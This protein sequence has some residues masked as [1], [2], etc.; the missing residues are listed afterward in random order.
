MAKKDRESSR[1][2]RREAKRV[3][4]DARQK[5]RA[6]RQKR[7]R[8]ATSVLKDAV[9]LVKH[10]NEVLAEAE[11]LRASLDVVLEEKRIAEEEK[12]ALRQSRD[13]AESKLETAK[14][15]LAQYRSRNAPAFQWKRLAYLEVEESKRFLAAR[16]KE[17]RQKVQQRSYARRCA[18]TVL[19]RERVFE[20][21]E[22]AQS[23][24]DPFL[25][26]AAKRGWCVVTRA[27]PT[28]VN[29]YPEVMLDGSY[30]M[31][32][33]NLLLALKGHKELVHVSSRVVHASHLCGNPQCVV[34]EHVVPETPQKN[35]RRKGCSVWE[36]CFHCNVPIFTCPHEPPCIKYHPDYVD[37]DALIAVAHREGQDPASHCVEGAPLSHA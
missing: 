26:I 5:K 19:N 35:N 33:P 28:K 3:R 12:A 37:M 22:L 30:C 25:A 1:E 18:L 34:K 6:R 21:A 14:N 13:D 11:G 9:V 32:L 10:Y 2:A 27:R 4:K 8:R 17:M 23:L 15:E 7:E 16:A 36:P 31:T 29:G 24:L 20:N